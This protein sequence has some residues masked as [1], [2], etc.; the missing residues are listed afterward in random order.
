MDI[1]TALAD[2]EAVDEDS[3]ADKDGLSDYIEGDGWQGDVMTLV[4]GK[5]Y[6]Y[7]SNSDEEKTLIFSTGAEKARS[8]IKPIKFVKPMMGKKA[9]S[10]AKIKS[11]E[12][13]F[14]INK[15]NDSIIPFKK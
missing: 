14:K 12:T 1:E 5:G 7:Y 3:F 2:F 6:M 9:N 11:N 15:V 4:P 8:S 10:E 13:K